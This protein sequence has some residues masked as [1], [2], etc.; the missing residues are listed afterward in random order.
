VTCFPIEV[1]PLVTGNGPCGAE[2]L[3]INV[4]RRGRSWSVMAVNFK[5]TPL[6]GT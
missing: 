4:I 2:T 1:H 6:L 3:F 5:P